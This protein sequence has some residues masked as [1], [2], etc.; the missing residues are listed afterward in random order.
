[1]STTAVELHSLR[2]TARRRTLL[3]I[4][5]L[6]VATGEVTAILGPNG[7]GKTTLLKVCLGLRRPTAGSVRI[8]G[9][10]GNRL[11]T[12][13]WARLRC[14]IGYV[15][16]Q[17][18][19]TSHM[20]LT[21]REIVAIGRTGRRGLLRALNRTDTAHV[22]TWLARLDLA[23][24]AR[25]SYSELSGGEQRKVLLAR[26]MVQ[27][28]EL[29]VLD[30]PTAYLDL[31]WRERIVATLDALYATQRPSILLVC[32]ELEVLPR[33]CTRVVV[34]TEGRVHATGTPEGVLT[35]ERVAALYG[36]GLTVAQRNGRF[37]VLPTGEWSEEPA[38]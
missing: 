11:G 19:T 25:A 10:D 2:V 22:E 29:L 31:G 30:E 15:P 37:A 23:P 20:P 27:E 16:Q 36:P 35:D 1:M 32:H 7:A 9:V 4:P 17:P 24:L 18:P 13:G 38:A 12:L 14:R 28:P 5:T 6:K 34:L 26:A 8:L 33:C 21:V 3:D